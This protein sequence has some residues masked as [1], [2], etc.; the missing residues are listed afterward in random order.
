SSHG[1]GGRPK[2]V[3]DLSIDP[4]VQ[5]G[6][7]QLQNGGPRGAV[8]SQV[9]LV[10][11][12]L[13]AGAVVVHIGDEHPQDGLGRSRRVA[14]VA[15]P[16]G[17]LIGIALLAVQRPL[18][19]QLR[20]LLAV[21]GVSHLKLEHAAAAARVS[22]AAALWSVQPPLG[23]S[24]AAAARAIPAAPWVGGAVGWPR[25]P[26]LSTAAAAPGLLEQLVALDAVAAKVTVGGGWQQVQRAH[27]P[28]L[29]HREREHRRR[30]GGRVVVDVEHDD[31]TLK[32]VHPALRGSYYR[33]LE[34]Q[35][36]LILVEDHLTLGELLA[37]DAP[38]ACAQL[39]GEVVDLQ[40][41]GARLK[42]ESH[43][44]RAGHDAQVR[45]D[46][47]YP[48]VGGA[49]LRQPISEELLGRRQAEPER[50]KEAAAQAPA[51][52][53]SRRPHPQHLLLLLLLLFLLTT[54]PSAPPSSGADR[55]PS[56]SPLSSP[57]KEGTRGRGRRGQKQLVESA[58][59][60]GVAV[61]PSFSS[62]CFFRKLLFHNSCNG[63]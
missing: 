47:A 55:L 50:Q 60:V 10:H 46:I 17:Q 4:H 43:L 20:L 36:A 56:P 7:A 34:V 19:D 52:R 15:H 29:L 25:A 59:G 32:Q 38:F 54:A 24:R 14:A 11:A 5:V 9:S 2:H 23:A 18:H 1:L 41:L 22:S 62:S 28:I 31:P 6:G 42:A 33:H 49:L 44:T 57:G 21:R 12:L 61:D 3:L 63:C 58:Y 45:S 39:T 16:Q 51:A 48:D 40:V 53:P 13:E 27:R 37:V 30:E 26:A 8:L 35:E